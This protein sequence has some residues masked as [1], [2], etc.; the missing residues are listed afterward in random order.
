VLSVSASV[1]R[2]AHAGA[3]LQIV[4]HIGSEL[5]TVLRTILDGII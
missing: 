4:I 1:P 2:A 3:A 5:P